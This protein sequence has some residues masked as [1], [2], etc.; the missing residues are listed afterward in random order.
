LDREGIG[1]EDQRH[2]EGEKESEQGVV[3]PLKKKRSG[4][5][6]GVN[7]QGTSPGKN[8][9]GGEKKRKETEVSKKKHRPGKYLPKRGKIN[10]LEEDGRE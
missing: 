1:Q 5:M 2:R 10:R 7:L 4:L 3:V 6:E 9:G 8:K